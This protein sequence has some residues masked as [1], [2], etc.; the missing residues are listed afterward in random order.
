MST[1]NESV[2]LPNYN[3]GITELTLF[4][5][6][7]GAWLNNN[8]YIFQDIVITPLGHERFSILITETDFSF[9]NI[10]ISSSFSTKFL[11]IGFTRAN[12]KMIPCPPVEESPE[13]TGGKHEEQEAEEGL[14]Y[15]ISNRSLENL[16]F[17]TVLYEVEFPN[18]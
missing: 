13:P 15:K 16:I 9:G 5:Q 1:T 4:E 17:P 3:Y 8:G 6:D 7:L 14:Q 2:T 12:D 11:R 18:G 10:I